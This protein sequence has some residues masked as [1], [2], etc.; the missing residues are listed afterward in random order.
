[1]KIAGQLLLIFLIACSQERKAENENVG[2]R[3]S[4]RVD[5]DKKM[6]AAS[7]LMPD[8][9][10]RL[11]PLFGISLGRSTVED[12]EKLKYKCTRIESGSRYCDVEDLD[13]WDHDHDRIVESVYLVSSDHLPDKWQNEFGFSFDKSY[14]EWMEALADDKFH[15]VIVVAPHV[16]EDALV[17]AV[18]IYSEMDSVK[19]RLEFAFG[20][21][22]GE[23]YETS[24][25]RSL[26]GITFDF[27]DPIQGYGEEIV[28]EE[29]AVGDTQDD[30]DFLRQLQRSHEGSES[31]SLQ[32]DP[33]PL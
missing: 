22:E 6:P 18:D 27:W 10:G 9:P 21:S 31:D 12:I 4:I 30:I 2:T 26:Y 5:V 13:F 24:S 14:D 17:A 19:I 33:F 1:M 32:N 11:F 3:D 29:E 23:G 16:V 20:N 8:I 28:E 25:P 7:V 15:V